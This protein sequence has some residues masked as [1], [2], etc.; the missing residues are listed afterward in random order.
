MLKKANNG[1]FSPGASER[2]QSCWQFG[3]SPE[4]L[5]L[6]SSCRTVGEY[7]EYIC[8]GSS[9]S[10]CRNLLRSNRKLT[11]QLCTGCLFITC[12]PSTRRWT[13]WGPGT[14]STVL[15]LVFFAGTEVLSNSPISIWWI[16]Q[17][18][19]SQHRKRDSWWRGVLG[20]WRSWCSLEQQ[21]GVVDEL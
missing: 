18:R 15:T 19:Q 11:H 16:N 4:S 5:I 17:D 3:F 20:E 8:V 21:F 2:N 13:P 1:E 12:L 6:I 7:I 9:H 14:F 10:V